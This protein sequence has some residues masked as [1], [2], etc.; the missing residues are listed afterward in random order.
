VS[1]M[2][3]CDTMS[4]FGSFTDAIDLR[5]MPVGA[6]FHFL[7]RQVDR[8]SDAD[9]LTAGGHLDLTVEPDQVA[10]AT[11]L[12]VDV[13]WILW[14]QEL[15]PVDRL[16][17]CRAKPNGH[18]ELQL[19]TPEVGS[20]HSLK[21]SCE[22]NPSASKAMFTEQSSDAWHWVSANAE[23]MKISNNLETDIAR[24]KGSWRTAIKTNVQAARVIRSLQTPADGTQE[25]AA[26]ESV[27]RFVQDTLGWLTQN[28][29]DEEGLWRKGGNKQLVTQ[30]CEQAAEHGYLQLDH[31]SNPHNLTTTILRWI[32]TEGGMIPAALTPQLI[33]AIGDS[34]RV[35]EVLG[36][37]ESAKRAQLRALV[38]HW[39]L[40]I[41]S[42]ASRMTP[43][44]M[45]TCTFV[46]TFEPPMEMSIMMKYRDAMTYLL[47]CD[48]IEF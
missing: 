33:A 9:W 14:G 19:W 45:A 7:N 8:L 15:G 31:D 34:A 30:L 13:L 3:C 47:E 27:P 20:Q 23:K 16:S 28:A 12:C 41:G 42:T 6:T 32:A 11:A 29:V 44:T 48:E 17:I 40:V 38:T 24:L 5:K 4:E 37:L 46:Q 2:F 35:T 1:K 26:A 25:S 36:Q 22:Q 18:F 10:E 39:K 21:E 43:E